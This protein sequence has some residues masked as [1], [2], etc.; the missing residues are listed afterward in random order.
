MTEKTRWGILATGTIANK[1]ATGLTALDDAEIAAVGSRSR[2]SA[3]R[4]GDKFDIPR[5]YDSYEALAADPQLD[6][7]YIGTPHSLHKENVLLCLGEG[8]AVLCEKPFTINAA[9]STRG[10][11]SCTVT[12][13]SSSWKPC[14]LAISR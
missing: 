8:K 14:G 13:A 7:I 6:A 3:E 11:R 1:F 2:E 12:R 9:E 4:F 10:H 5:R